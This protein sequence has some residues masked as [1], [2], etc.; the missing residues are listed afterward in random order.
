MLERLGFS[1]A[2]VGL[3]MKCVTTVRYQIKVNGV[4]TEQFIPTWGLRQGDPLSPYLFVICA[5]GLSALLH[6]SER[7]GRLSGVR[8]CQG[9][10]TIT[11]LF[12]AD[13]SVL[14]IKADS[15]EAGEL[16]RILDLYEECS[17][18]CIKK[19]NSAIIFSANTRA[20][21]K[22]IVKQGTGISCETWNERYLGLP[23][24]VG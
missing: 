12:F 10:P 18:Q 9:A 8:V 7:E 6:A 24:Y 20:E 23:V 3:L 15:G 14:M 13:D 5:E 1:D 16:K 17:G 4:L 2:W 11:H 22:E 19:E 21:Q